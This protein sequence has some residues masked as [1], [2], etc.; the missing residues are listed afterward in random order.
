[1]AELLYTTIER[2]LFRNMKGHL[3]VFGLFV[4]IFRMMMHLDLCFWL[5]AWAL[6]YSDISILL[7]RMMN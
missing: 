1:M 6:L 2:R 4:L 5:G 7:M 3:L